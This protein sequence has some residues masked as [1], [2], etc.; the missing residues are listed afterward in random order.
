MPDKRDY[1]EVL[2]VAK[3]AAADEIKKAY[4]KLAMQWHP[5]KNQGNKDAEEKF[6]ELGEA[7]DVLSDADKRAAYDRYGHSAFNG[8]G[9]GGG[10]AGGFH[11]PVDLFREVFGG[12]FGGGFE[13][14]F[15][16]GGGRRKSGKQRGS[17][18]RYDLQLTLE[19]AAKG[20]EKELSIE[21]FVACEICNNTGSKSGSGT[22][23]CSGC[24]GRGVITRSAGIFV[25]QSECPACHG[26]GELISDPCDTC[27]GEGRVQKETNIKIRIPAGVDTGTRLRS[28][29]NGD[30]GLRG[31]PSGDLYVFLIIKKHDFF[32][33]EGN[34]LFCEVPISFATAALG[35]ETKVPTLDGNSSIKIPP[36]TQGGTVFRL[37]E[38]GMSNLSGGRRGDLH[39]TL[40]VEVP[41]KLNNAQQEKLREF[42]ESIGDKNKPME[43]S[44][45]DKAKRFFDL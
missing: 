37:K 8:P 9:G 17:D 39:V 41:T 44:F 42:A 3:S 14:M 28:S 29:G 4:R 30:S 26:T 43:G 18:L 32:E 5:D 45:F 2:G 27:R 15:G 7:Y 12:A 6:K 23:K 10:G 16:N 20:V 36:G 31:G 33:R 25:Q 1:Y 34:D 38:K 24:G 35:G 11:D 13:D 40:Q 22:K 21:R 19:E